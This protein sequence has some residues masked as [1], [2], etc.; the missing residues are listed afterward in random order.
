MKFSTAGTGNVAWHFSK[1]LCN[2]GHE[3]L[4]VYAR[5][6][7]KGKA[8]A[9]DLNADFINSPSAFSSDNDIIIIAVKDDAIHDVSSAI[10]QNIFTLHP[11]GSTSIDALVQARKAVAWPVQSISKTKPL[12]YSKIPFLI[13]ASDEA[14]KKM[15]EDVFGKISSNVFYTNSE[16]RAR[17]HMAAVFA[18]NFVNQM[19][20]IA[21][22]ILADD[23]LPLHILFPGMEEQVEK[24][25]LVGPQQAQTGPALRGDIETINKHLTFLKDK[26]E[27]LEIYTLLTNRILENYHGKKL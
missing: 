24:V 12:D 22:K 11:S 9:K 20:S 10:S 8:L 4:Q 1:M 26:P 25:K 3:L 14:G 18:N 7:A 17:A 23:N 13:E 5:D 21:E 19:Y 27:L 2:A 16:Q 15:L 6:G